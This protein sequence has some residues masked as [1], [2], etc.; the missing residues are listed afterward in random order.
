M[1]IAKY[2]AYRFFNSNFFTGQFSFKRNRHDSFERFTISFVSI[3]MTET[4]DPAKFEQDMQALME[5][6]LPISESKIKGLK[7]KAMAHPKVRRSSPFNS[8]NSF[9]EL[10]G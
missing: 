5:A 10:S 1:Q 3:I 9:Y 2:K 8:D 6:K 7:N 4:W